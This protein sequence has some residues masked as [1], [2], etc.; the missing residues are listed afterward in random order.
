MRG[1]RKQIVEWAL[2]ATDEVKLEIPYAAKNEIGYGVS[3][4]G[5][6]VQRMSNALIVLKRTK[7]GSRTYFV[8][9]A[10][11]RVF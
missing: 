4:N 8:V 11:P 7:I 2:E 9:T 3:R 1:N 5:G 6:S 10:F